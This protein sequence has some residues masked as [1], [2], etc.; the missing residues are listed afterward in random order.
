[1]TAGRKGH[2][3]NQKGNR[4]NLREEASAEVQVELD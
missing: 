2:S 1:M 4:E 3:G